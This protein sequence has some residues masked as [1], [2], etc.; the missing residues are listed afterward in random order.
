[1]R[2]RRKRKVKSAELMEADLTPMIDVTFQLIAFFM[3]LINFSEV[4]RAEEIQLPTSQLAKPPAEPP[5][6]Q[7]LMNLEPSGKVKFAGQTIEQIDL[8]RPIFNLEVSAAQR[9]GVDAEDISV[10]IRA[11]EDTPTGLVQELISKCQE[12]ELQSFSLRVE[13][14][15]N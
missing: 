8:M 4:D 1:M 3:F 6:Y 11:H 9:E 7:I 15:A 2:R 14:K 10:V 13:D 12:A 5:E